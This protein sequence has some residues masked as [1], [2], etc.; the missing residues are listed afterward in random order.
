MKKRNGAHEKA[1]RGF[2]M[3]AGGLVVGEP[4]LNFHGIM[5]GVP[6]IVDEEAVRD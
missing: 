2:D 6:V 1:I 4:L 5:T 3:H